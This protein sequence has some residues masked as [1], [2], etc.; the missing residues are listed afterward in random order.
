[1]TL[2]ARGTSVTSAELLLSMTSGSRSTLL[3]ESAEDGL[4]TDPVVGEVD[5]TGAGS[6][7]S[8]CIGV[9][10]PSSRCGLASFRWNQR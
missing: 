5:R 3:G 4:A 10:W 9:N 6:P 7:V 8:A 1:V 2:A